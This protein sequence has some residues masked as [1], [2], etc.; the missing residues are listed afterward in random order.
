MVVEC[1]PQSRVIKPKPKPESCLE[2]AHEY[3]YAHDTH[4]RMARA[5]LI[6]VRMST[7]RHKSNLKMLKAVESADFEFRRVVDAVALAARA[8]AI[9]QSLTDA[10]RHE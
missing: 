3:V 4:V 10:V 9:A 8:G 7:N 1:R 2:Y 5:Q 6:D